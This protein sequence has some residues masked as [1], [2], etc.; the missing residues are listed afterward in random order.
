MSKLKQVGDLKLELSNMTEKLRELAETAG[1]ELANFGRI[2]T[3][4]ITLI[5]GKISIIT[6]NFLFFLAEIPK[7]R[8]AEV[9]MKGALSAREAH[10]WSE[11]Q[12]ET[13]RLRTWINQ[14]PKIEILLR[15]QIPPKRRKLFSKL[16]ADDDISIAHNIAND[17]FLGSIH[18]VLN[19]EKQSATAQEHGCFADIPLSQ[20]LFIEHVHA[21]KRVLLA[22]R[23]NHPMRFLDVGCGGG[24]K[25]LSAATFFDRA[26]GLEFDLGYVELAKA[27]FS[28][29]RADRCEVIQADGLNYPNYDAYDVVYFYRPMRHIEQL[30]ELEDKIIGNVRPGTLI[31]A[32]YL[33]FN[34]RY[35]ELG[36]ARI[37]RQLY[38]AHSCQRNADS[39]RREAE[40]TGSFAL[41]TTPIIPSIW[42][43]ILKASRAKGFAPVS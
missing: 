9:E 20:N 4:R 13:Y 6:N 41:Y 15:G 30:K 18:Q 11:L 12:N 36:C 35:K 1:A 39:L 3:A 29:C 22:R 23:P 37:E 27:L 28:S 38:I 10:E 42:D 14:W 34:Y 16:V 26:D 25:V 32:P 17:A 43:P 31:V 21:A 33:S 40:F 5:I 2:D 7:V 19:P 8:A 24:M